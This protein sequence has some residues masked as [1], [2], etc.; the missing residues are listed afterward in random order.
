MADERLSIRG[1]IL[2]AFESF[3]AILSRATPEQAVKWSLSRFGEIAEGPLKI[4]T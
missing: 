4:V 3:L 2:L 1:P